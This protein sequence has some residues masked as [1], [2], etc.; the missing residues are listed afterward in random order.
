YISN[1][2]ALPSPSPRPSPLGPCL[3]IEF[4]SLGGSRSSSAP[5]SAKSTTRCHS[6]NYREKRRLLPKCLLFALFAIIGV[7]LLLVVRSFV[8]FR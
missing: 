4:A 7:R 1:R 3:Y 2:S 6:V 8:T 5:P